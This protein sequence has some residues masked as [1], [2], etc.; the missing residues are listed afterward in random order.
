MS[1]PLARPLPP[2]PT[3]EQLAAADPALSA[4]VS[5]SA[6]SGKTQVLT[7][8]VIR[9][10]LA[11][12]R[13]ERIL[14]ITYTK[15]AAG[16]MANRII[17]RL[18]ELATTDSR[19][20]EAILR[21]LL[22][23]EPTGNERTQAL[24]LFADVLDAPG[25][26]R[27]QTIH[28]FCQ[29]V[30]RRFPVEAEIAPHFT[31]IDERTQSELLAE[32]KRSVMRA[33][34][35]ALQQAIALLTRRINEVQVDGL[36][37]GLAGSSGRLRA[38]Y[39]AHGGRE[40]LIRRIRALLGL[41]EE[42][43]VAS[44]WRRV[45]VDPEM[46]EAGLARAAQVLVEHGTKSARERG[47]AIRAFLASNADARVAAAETYLD[48][49]LT[50][51]REPRAPGGLA[52]NAAY[53]ADPGLADV[54][55]AEQERVLRCWHRICA[56]ETAE[57]TA[58]LIMVAD[59]IL[60]AYERMKRA[61]AVLDYEDLITRT[62]RLLSERDR[63]PWVLY[64]LDGGLD[65]VLIDEAQD[66]NYPQ[67]EI[68]GRIADE[69]FAEEAGGRRSL[70]A[71]G[72]VKQSIFSFQGADPDAFVAANSRF[73]QLAEQ[74]RRDWANLQLDRS[75]RSTG[76]VLAAV[77]AVF[78]PG[79]P[80]TDGLGLSQGEVLRHR[81]T[82]EGHAGLVELWP[83]ITVE[84]AEEREP[85]RPPVEPE[86]GET[87][88]ARLAER[89]ARRIQRMIGREMLESKG[90]PVRAGDILVLVRARDVLVEELIRQLKE[91]H[92]P[93]AG[94]D[95]LKLTDHLAVMDLVALGEAML[96]PEDDLTLATVL[97]SP[98]VG[99]DEEA[100]FDLAYGR[101]GKRLWTRLRERAE[102]APDSLDGRAH[103]LLE[104]WRAQ[105]D[106]VTPFAFF[107]G[108]LNGNDDLL[109]GEGRAPLS[110]RA[111]LIARLGF[112]AAD[113]IDE[114]LTL[115]QAEERA[116]P[117]S[118]QGFLFRLRTADIEIKRELEQGGADAVRVMTVH[119]AKGLQAPIVFLPD[120]VSYPEDRDPVRWY[121][122]DGEVPVPLW[123]RDAKRDT[124]QTARARED[125]RRRVQEEYNR[126]LYV[127]M[128]R[129]EDRLYICGAAG[130]R[131][132]G[133]TCWYRMIEAG[134]GPLLQ[135][136]DD[137]EIGEVRR[138]ASPQETAPRGPEP[139][140]GQPQPE[141]LPAWVRQ[142]APPE[143]RPPRPL[144]PSRPDEP[145]APVTSP[146]Q[147]WAPSA[148]PAARERGV[149]AHLLLQRL[150]DL[151]PEKRRAAALAWLARSHPD[152][153]P[154]DAE[155][156][157]D[158]VLAI[159]DD[160][161]F[162]PLFGPGSLA[163]APLVAVLSDGR[164]VSGQVDRL[165]VRDTGVLVVD[166]KTNRRPPATVEAVPAI[167]VHQ[168]AAYR[169]ALARMFPGR[170]VDCALLWT[171]GP[172]LMPLPAAMLD[173][174]GLA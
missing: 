171:E 5:A 14:C 63:A 35:P 139:A 72:D 3:P 59:R 25:G 28:A 125:A 46:N 62:A 170:P 44:A 147:P 167:Y 150:P 157:T 70:F 96:L 108:V 126:L 43:G 57:A 38:A 9:L 37:A 6:G 11:G 49:W 87:P 60:A 53:A 124:P 67:W 51:T 144:A 71:V 111:R 95:R 145:E 91:R 86:P 92:V 119:G 81:L 164:V 24:R 116:F 107:D 138:L 66:T 65:H 154:A 23:R 149:A 105:V 29:S 93:V 152:W 115:A 68:V 7:D 134:L 148:G 142:P 33:P 41:A 80:A 84:G 140:A 130:K 83:L 162:A 64:K 137:P 168:M 129:A 118:M 89:I 114:F 48:Q 132:P 78:A 109:A 101:G 31:V 141:P 127:A 106:L 156:L 160:P 155:A 18:A 47:V 39:D 94:R 166:Y 174:V 12:A 15:A 143:P 73:R 16:E 172:V 21:R 32:A 90:R 30:L 76:P 113:P 88:K 20:R 153:A 34:G 52:S 100:L 77:D 26:L 112:D 117:P 97:K 19:R 133:D 103:A 10:L 159:L 120:T 27:I 8:R 99:Y 110:G 69:F 61:R 104:R 74:A 36:M 54:L 161:A 55:L 45:V 123:L 4:F 42:E 121:G 136:A 98:L 146:V 17:E 13:P 165:L 151:P 173:A 102:A 163:E 85:W 122:P 22:D 135:K 40:G 50:R 2:A 82:R 79:M 56:C 1:L 75:F 131:S 58:A 128:T 158:Q 169:A